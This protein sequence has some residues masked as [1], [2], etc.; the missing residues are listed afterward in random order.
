MKNDYEI[1]KQERERI[2]D[3]QRKHSL[4]G[5]T[6]KSLLHFSIWTVVLVGYGGLLFV[7]STTPQGEDFSTVYDI[8]GAVHIT[9]G[10]SHPP[11]NSNPPSS[12]WHYA[13]PTNGGFYNESIPDEAVIHNLEHGDIWIA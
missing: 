7:R 12:G 2:R 9:D 1:K 13:Q 4:R 6:I 5:K 3:E 11:H 8:Q 10:S